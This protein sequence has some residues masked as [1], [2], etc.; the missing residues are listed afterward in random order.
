MHQPI[1]PT[2]GRT[3]LFVLPNGRRRGEIRPATVVRVNGEGE[4]Q[5]CNLRVIT[6]GPNDENALVASSPD[7]ES[8]SLPYREPDWRGSVAYHQHAEGEAPKPGTWH[9][10]PY[11][12]QTATPR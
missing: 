12:L 1:N 8:I 11:Q 5:T 3:V 4:Y 10:M 6:D 9:W 7:G 2:V